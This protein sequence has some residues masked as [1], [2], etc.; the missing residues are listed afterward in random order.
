MSKASVEEI[1]L[2]SNGLRGHIQEAFADAALSHVEENEN[3]L[4]KFH[5]TYQ[6]DDRDVRAQRTKEKL[7]K[8]W[9]LHGALQDARRTDQRR[10][11]AP[12]R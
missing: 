1:K 3:I 2:E 8:A 11:V 5:G 10:P 9:E 7:D 6:Q 12:A 4:L